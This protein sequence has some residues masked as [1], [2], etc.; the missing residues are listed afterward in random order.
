[1]KELEPVRVRP[2]IQVIAEVQK[3]YRLLGHIKMKPGHSLFAFNTIS[4]HLRKVDLKKEGL[5]TNNGK[6]ITRS[7]VFQ[8]PNTIY[9]T[10]LNAKNALKKILKSFIKH[11]N[12]TS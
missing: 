9:V 8:E 11:K 1:M 3:E 2:D 6:V 5:I 10:S 12:Q 7:K 4:T